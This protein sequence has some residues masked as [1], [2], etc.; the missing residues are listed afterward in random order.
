M[1]W[2]TSWFCTVHAVGSSSLNK[3][4]ETIDKIFII[5][6]TDIYNLSPRLLF[7]VCNLNNYSDLNPLIP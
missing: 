2:S 3:S 6:K 1:V 5:Y 7:D 4:S